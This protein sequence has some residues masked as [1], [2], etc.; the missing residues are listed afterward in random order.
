M[1]DVPRSQLAVY[2]AAAIAIA[3]LGARYVSAGE[4]E[5]APQGTPAVRVEEERKG[6]GRAVV[7]V[8]GAVREPGVYRLREG[9]RV[10]DAVDRAGGATGRA[11]LTLVNL[12]AEVEDGRQVVVPQ[13]GPAGGTPPAGGTAGSSSAGVGG[14]TPPV[15]LNTATLEQLD[16]LEGVGPGIAQRILDY[17][18]AQGSFGS[19]DELGQVPGIGEKRLASLRD[20]VTV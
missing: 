6:G 14:V 4:E 2:V 10:A 19:V 8:A 1:A 13:R 20:K 9:D 12:A 15:N 16:T 5:A 18:D 11:D 7:H 17:R 3:L